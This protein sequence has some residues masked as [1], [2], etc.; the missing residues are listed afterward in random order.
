MSPLRMPGA[1]S[2]EGLE[3]GM[4]ARVG[5]TP[6]SYW[7]LQNREKGFRGLAVR[8]WIF[9]GEHHFVMMRAVCGFWVVYGEMSPERERLNKG[10]FPVSSREKSTEERERE[11]E[12][13][14]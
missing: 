2:G 11:N 14:R 5:V 9:R 7:A 3:A 8:W 1:G 6:R 4:L 13:K 12:M 10:D